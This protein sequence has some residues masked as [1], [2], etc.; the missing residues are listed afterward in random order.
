[1]DLLNERAMEKFNELKR[2]LQLNVQ[3]DSMSKAFIAQQER[4]QE[5]MDASF[6]LSLD[7]IRRSPQVQRHMEQAIIAAD[8]IDKAFNYINSLEMS[9]NLSLAMGLIISASKT[10][11]IEDLEKAM[12]AIKSEINSPPYITEG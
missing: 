9:P 4:I 11:D 2:R 1:M 8:D 5:L 6:P 3:K 7:D 12:D 10:K